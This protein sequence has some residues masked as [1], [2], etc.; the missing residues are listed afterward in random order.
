MVIG[1]TYWP[2]SHSTPR[3]LGDL[4]GGDDHPAVVHGL[5]ADLVDLHDRGLFADGVRASQ[6]ASPSS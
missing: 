2:K 5:R 6:R 3:H 1:T 4:V